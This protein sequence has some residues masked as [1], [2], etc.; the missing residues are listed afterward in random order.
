MS[1]NQHPTPTSTATESPCLTCAAHSGCMTTSTPEKVATTSPW[2]SIDDLSDY[3]RSPKGTIY[4]WRYLGEG[5]PA[6]G[7]AGR[8]PLYHRDDVD[9]WLIEQAAA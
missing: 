5:P 3:V 7:K 4:R 2:L 9:A 8:R 1:T 6:R